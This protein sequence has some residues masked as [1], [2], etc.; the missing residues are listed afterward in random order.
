MEIDE[1]GRCI[2]KVFKLITLLSLIILSSNIH[3]SD[4]ANRIGGGTYDLDVSEDHQM[5]GKYISYTREF[6]SIAALKVNYFKADHKTITSGESSGFEVSLMA[7]SH[8]A[9]VFNVSLGLGYFKESWKMPDLNQQAGFSAVSTRQLGQSRGW[10][11]SKQNEAIS[12]DNDYDGLFI[13]MGAGFAYKYIAVNYWFSV[14]H[15]GTYE[16][17]FGSN[18][19]GLELIPIVQHIELAIRF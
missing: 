7:V 8:F 16:D 11:S 3:A 2:M 13:V 4:F 12:G 1:V 6:A 17:N 10:P 19:P 5:K 15:K 9:R 18:L 14:R